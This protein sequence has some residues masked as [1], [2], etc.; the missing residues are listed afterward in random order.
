MYRQ[1]NLLKIAILTLTLLLIVQY[2]FYQWSK[3]NANLF[4]KNSI[5]RSV[6]EYLAK[7]EQSEQIDI[8]IESFRQLYGLKGVSVAIV[9]DGKLVFTK[10]YGYANEE[11]KILA[12]SDNLF[13]LASVSKLITSVAIMKLIEEGKLT[14]SDKV[15]GKEGIINDKKYLQIKDKRLLDVTVLNLL[16]HSGG[17]T[18]KYGDPMFNP[19]KICSLMKSDP[20]ADMD[21]YIKFAVT[22]MLHFT[23]GTIYS[24]SNMGY[25][26][27]GE[28]IERVSG[29]PYDEYVREKIL[30]PMGIIDMCLANNRFEDRL[31][32]EVTYYDYG[33]KAYCQS[34]MGDSTQVPKIYGGNNIRMLGAAGGWVASAPDLARLMVSIDGFS[35]VK[36]ILSPKSVD[37]MTGKLGKTLGWKEIYKDGWLRTGTFSGTAALIYRQNDGVEW[38]FLSNTSTYRGPYFSHY[39]VRMMKKITNKIDEWPAFDLFNYYNFVI[40]E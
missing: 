12:S 29:L 6:I 13:R 23:P 22:R 25:L 7:F 1:G 15:F 2:P 36:D 9:R 19:L 38:V 5:K 17:W 30:K 32:R 11:N 14:L 28:V 24:Y 8:E 21:T 35:N 10:G 34:F 18:Q 37:E 16:N 26:F 4:V 39:V 20:P 27:L 40:P 3:N 33:D 31:P